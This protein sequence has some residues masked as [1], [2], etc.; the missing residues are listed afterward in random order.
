[1]LSKNQMVR[2]RKAFETMY[3]S[4]CTVTIHEEYEKPNGSTG[5]QDVTVL[6]DE[7]CKVQFTGVRSAQAGDAAAT[8]SQEI[9]LF[10]SPDIEIPAGSKI[11][12]KSVDYTHSGVV[13]K[14][15][16]HQEIVLNLWERWS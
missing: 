13:A 3:D 12:V 6:T 11:T 8:V 9:R 16:T 10:I 15:E 5:F 4:T 14:Y 7:P 1:M 2:V